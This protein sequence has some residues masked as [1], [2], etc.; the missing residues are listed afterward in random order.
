MKTEQLKEIAEKI[1]LQEKKLIGMLSPYYFDNEYSVCAVESFNPELNLN[2]LEMIESWLIKNGYEI[3]YQYSQRHKD[4]RVVI[5][6][7]LPYKGFVY[8]NKKKSTAFL[9]AFYNL[10]QE[11]KK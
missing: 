4:W 10:I 11:D 6:V 3:H 7:P 5:W 2:Q 1:G 9:N 8:D